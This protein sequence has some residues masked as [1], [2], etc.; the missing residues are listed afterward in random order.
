MQNPHKKIFARLISSALLVTFVL[1]S[2]VNFSYPQQDEPSSQR[3][4]LNPILEKGI[5]QYKHEN[6]DEA[7]ETLKKAKSESPASSLAS[8]YLGLTYKQLQDYKNAI[9]QL[10]DAV[11]Y[12][13]KIKGALIELIDCL[14]Q[15]GQLAEAKKWIAEAEAEGIRPAQVAFL[16]GMVLVKDNEGADAVIAFENARM[17]DASM[18]QACNYQIGIIQIKEKRYDDARR[19]F[20][21]VILADPNSNMANFANEYM[22]AIERMKEASKPFKIEAGFAWQYDDNV[23]LKPDD[24]TLASNITDKADSREVYTASAEYNFRPNEKFGLRALYNFY[25]AKQNDLGFYD[26]VNNNFGIQPTLYFKNSM[27]TFPTAFAYTLVN[28]KA[29]EVSP[30]TN[31]VYNFMLG[32]NMFQANVRYQFKHYLWGT[33]PD[34]NR[35]GSDVGGGLGWYYFYAKNKGFIN[36]RY[37]LNREWTDGMNWRYLGNRFSATLLVPVISDKLNATVTG[38][39]YFQNFTN[40]NSVYGVYRKDGVYTLSALIAYKFY[41][42]SEIQ[43][44]FTHVKDDSNIAVYKYNRNIYSAG[45]NF[46]F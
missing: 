13:P 46:K 28:D 40:T 34:E 11:T 3:E 39:A 29:Y 35:D 10:K 42:D 4:N 26:M 15:T 30:T 18:T 45:V 38:D 32:S 1:V 20:N 16:K 21:E 2:S 17:L 22:G 27:L 41:K 25:F 8:Y 31:A 23:I 37:A 12:S 14:Y 24:A 36:L 5:G 33:A 9:S 43:L 19:A 6:Y 7:L 44:Q